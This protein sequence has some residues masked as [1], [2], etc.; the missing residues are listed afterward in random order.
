[1]KDTFLLGLIQNIAVLLTFSM[2]YDYFWA[3]NS[4][5]R[6]FLYKLGTG[7]FVGGVGVVL[8]LT[9]WTFTEGLFFDTRSVLL[10]VSG[11]FLGGI[12]TVIAMLIL[13]IYR[14]VLGGPG[15]WMGGWA[16]SRWDRRPCLS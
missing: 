1:M 6:T 3:R 13:A 11:L 2:L 12:P 15:V 16:Q 8:I 14:L 5:R 7:F 4:G 9:P 10:S